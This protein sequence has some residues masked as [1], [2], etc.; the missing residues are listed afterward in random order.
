MQLFSL[1]TFYTVLTR[2]WAR[3]F[4]DSFRISAHFLH[5]PRPGCFV[6]DVIVIGGCFPPHST[7]VCR[8]ACSRDS[9]QIRANPK[10][11][12]AKQKTH[13]NWGY[14]TI[15]N[16]ILWPHLQS[17]KDRCFDMS[18]EVL[19]AFRPVGCDSLMWRKLLL[20]ASGEDNG[21][22]WSWEE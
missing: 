8:S 9:A 18:E 14:Y 3:H 16:H 22:D 4:A 6:Y 5:Q 17:N 13:T 12:K 21:T 15:F 10:T 20:F 2:V 7:C 1:F 19:H 11:P